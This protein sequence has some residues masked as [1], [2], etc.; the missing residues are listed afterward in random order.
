MMEK[1][2][3]EQLDQDRAETKD[4]DKNN[5]SWRRFVVSGQNRGNNNGGGHNSGGHKSM[6]QNSS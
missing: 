5:I 3:H 1:L 6:G 2:E 4:I